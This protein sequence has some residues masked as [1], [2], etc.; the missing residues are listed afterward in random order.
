MKRGKRRNLSKVGMQDEA[1]HRSQPSEELDVTLDANARDHFIPKFLTQRPSTHERRG[2]RNLISHINLVAH[3]SQT[4]QQA[5]SNL[6]RP[7]PA[8]L[9]HNYSSSLYSLVDKSRKGRRLLP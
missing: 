6:I 3:T 7:T 9:P 5:V 1:P 8:T 4:L 2:K